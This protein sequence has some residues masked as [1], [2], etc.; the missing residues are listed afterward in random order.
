MYNTKY[1][2]NSGFDN[3]WLPLDEPRHRSSKSSSIWSFVLSKIEEKYF[4][5][6]NW[7]AN[8]SHGVLPDLIFMNQLQQ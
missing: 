3:T 6:H 8:K 2:K 1:W 7:Q 5:S 4:T